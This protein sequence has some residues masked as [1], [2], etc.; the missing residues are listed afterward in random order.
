MLT[1]GGATGWLATL[2]DGAALGD[3]DKGGVVVVLAG[4]CVVAVWKIVASCSSAV[5]CSL[6]MVAKGAAGAGSCNVWTRLRA[7]EV[8]ASAEDVLG[9][10][11]LWGKNWTTSDVRSDAVA[12]TY[13]V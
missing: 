6:P 12:V 5:I 10:T 4:L 13:T 1:L 3:T 11:Q 9:I 7:A 8:A 2:G